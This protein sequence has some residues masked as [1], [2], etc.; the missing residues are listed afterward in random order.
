MAGILRQAFVPFHVN[1]QLHLAGPLIL[2]GLYQ[3]IVD[4]DLGYTVSDLYEMLRVAAV[5]GFLQS[6]YP[7]HATLTYPM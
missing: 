1:N 5:E 2:Q 7:S 4:K 6:V 3:C